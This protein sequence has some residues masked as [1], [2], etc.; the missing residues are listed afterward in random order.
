[1]R[2][3]VKGQLKFLEELDK[4]ERKRLEEAEREMLIRA[5][6]SR[7]KHEDPEQLKLKEKA[8]AVCIAIGDIHYRSFAY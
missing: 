1:M 8:K 2:N 3:E 7:S 5:A 4:L 6:K